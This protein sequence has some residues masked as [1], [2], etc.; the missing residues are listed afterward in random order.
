MTAAA[1]AATGPGTR[2]SMLQKLAT[3]LSAQASRIKE[4][5]PMDL[6]SLEAI[7]PTLASLRERISKRRLLPFAFLEISPRPRLD[8]AVA[9]GESILAQGWSLPDARMNSL[10]PPIQWEGWPRS[11]SFHLHAWQPIQRLLVAYDLSADRR[12]FDAAFAMAWDWM[13]T[14]KAEPAGKPLMPL[15]ANI[16]GEKDGTWWYDM[17]VAQRLQ[18]LSYI[19]DIACRLPDIES[20]KI[21][22]MMEHLLLH[23]GVLKS[24]KLF[25]ATTNHGFFQALN[26]LA[27]TQRFPEFDTDGSLLALSHKRMKQMLALQFSESMVHKEHS[28][29]YHFMVTVALV[30]AL[31]CGAL[32]DELTAGLKSA[33]ENLGWMIGP[34]G[35][36]VCFGDTD[37]RNLFDRNNAEFFSGEPSLLATV[38]QSPETP[39]GIR[40]LYDAGY[41]FARVYATDVERKP[42]NASYLAQIAGFHS[43]THKHADHLSFVWHDRKRDIL[44]DPARYAYIGKTTPDSALFEQGFWYSD[45]KR[46]YVES[47]QAHNCVE[48][49]GRSYKRKGAK[50]F[51]SALRYAGEQDGLAVTDCEVTHGRTVRHR[52]V[53]VMAPGRFL[54]VLDWLNDRTQSHDYR[55]WF[56]FAPD[57][58]VDKGEDGL[59]AKAQAGGDAAAQTVKVFNLMEENAFAE[60]VRGREEPQLQGWTSDAAYSLIPSTSINVEALARPMARFATL[61][62]LDDLEI[63]RRGTRFNAT[64]RSGKIR[65]TDESG[66]HLLAVTMSEPG[67]VTVKLD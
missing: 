12:F 28:P 49:D 13:Q 7:R 3:R 45:P 20:G 58:Q 30:N 21:V 17:A 14:V 15:V 67:S 53:L 31:R 29:G 23:H 24:D 65:L 1:F 18:R 42:E 9:D 25:S 4:S 51:G 19:L 46:I 35:G 60:P 5:M 26:Q 34:A 66:K 54:L 44:L 56:Q 48:I 16:L 43:R 57:W 59:I 10:K 8:A 47:T 63:D 50:R 37:P 41:A 2:L 32:N 61:F 64:L 11:F 33:M 6:S 38:R 40:A 55:Q 27:A 52:R 22:F 62:A 39:A 36:I